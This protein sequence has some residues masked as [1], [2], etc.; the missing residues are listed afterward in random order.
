VSSQAVLSRR[1]LNRALLSRQLLLD[2][3]DLPDE[4][5]RRR[6]TVIQAI[7]HL[8]GLQAQAP[9]PPYYGLWS[10]LGGFRPEDLAALLTDR[11]AV[12]IALMR[13]TIHLVSARDCLPLRRLVQPVLERGLRGTFGK[14]L[15]GVDPA[16]VAAAGRELVE[17]EPMTFSRLGDALAGH[18]PDHP[19]AALAQAVRAYVPLVQVPPRA[20]WGRAGQSAHTSAEHWLGLA[21]EQDPADP[22]RDTLAGLVTRYLAA[23]GPAT[24]RD[25]AAW[26]GLTGLRA[27]MDQLRPSLVTF[28][29]EQGAELFDL[30]SAPRPGEEAPAPVRLA[31]E[32][33]N[34]LLSHADRSRVIRAENLKRF[35]T[36]NGVF[37][38]AVLIDGFVAGMWRLARTKSTAT[39]TVELFGSTRERAQVAREAERM[40]AFCAS[41]A[42][43]DIRFAPIA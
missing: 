40:L 14:Q 23:F 32:F 5:G 29:D 22:E 10:R 17:S 25:V 42:S 36:I 37:P 2:R 7:E 43:H 21:A 8:I 3:V 15:A 39:L 27:V 9:F 1:A 34:L 12:R 11:R 28:R 30:P 33:D 19:P 16:A 13:G 35:Y 41:G 26:S 24:A 4:A 38:G 20:V 31:A 6:A 18:W